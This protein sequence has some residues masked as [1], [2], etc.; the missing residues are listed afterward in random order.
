MLS[1]VSYEQPTHELLI[2]INQSHNV[3]VNSIRAHH[4]DFKEAQ[5]LFLGYPFKSLKHNDRVAANDHHAD[6]DFLSPLLLLESLV[7]D[8]VH[9]YIVAS[10]DA[11]DFAVAVQLAEHPLFHILLQFGLSLGHLG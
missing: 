7:E 6:S 4:P 2:A 3:D 5:S 1:I 9:E 10:Q 11:D 8:D